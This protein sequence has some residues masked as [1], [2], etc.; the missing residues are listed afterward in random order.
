M[1]RSSNR[2]S[3]KAPASSKRPDRRRP[4][5]GD[6]VEPGRLDLLVE[7]GLG[8]HAA[9]ADERHARQAE[10]FLDLGDLGGERLGIAGVA[11]EHFDR[12]RAAVGGAQEAIDDLQLALLAVAVV[13]ELGQGQQR[14]SR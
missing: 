6:P 2:S 5:G 13:A 3:W 11:V 9:V 7:A 1:S 14:P 10:A 8:D 4:Q 12:H